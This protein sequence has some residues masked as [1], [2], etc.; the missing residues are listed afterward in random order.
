MRLSPLL[1]I[2]GAL[3]ARL[4]GSLPA[5]PGAE[6]CVRAGDDW[7][8]LLAAAARDDP[9][10]ALA[11]CREDVARLWADGPTRALLARRG[12]R[13]EL[14]SGLCVMCCAVCRWRALTRR[15]FLDDVE[16]VA[17]LAYAPTTE[18]VLRAR[19]RTVGIEE[20]HLLIET[21]R[22]TPRLCGHAR[23]DT[24]TRAGG[25]HEWFIY[26]V[27]GHRASRNRWASYFDDASAILFLAPLAFDAF[28]EEDPSVNRLVCTPPPFPSRTLTARCRTTATRSGRRSAGTSCCGA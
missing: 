19:L 2:E 27:D 9:T 24:D 3:A 12:I 16:R 7:P 13:L 17:Q 22:G 5:S 4:H 26:D 1:A 6:L 8:A 10:A 14:E 18:D 15:S 25:G 20:H 28:L 11:A 21:D 23:P